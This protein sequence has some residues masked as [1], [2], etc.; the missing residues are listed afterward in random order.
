M[1][2]SAVMLDKKPTRK[3][4]ELVLNGDD[5]LVF[6]GEGAVRLGDVMLSPLDCLRLSDCR[7]LTLRAEGKGR[8]YLAEFSS[9]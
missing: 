6:C 3:G 2:F 4:A 5:C 7:D 8:L 1:P 9:I